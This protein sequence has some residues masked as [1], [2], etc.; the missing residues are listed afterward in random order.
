MKCFY[1]F[2]Q[3]LA[4]S[5]IRWY[6]WPLLA[7]LLRPYRCIGCGRR[8][9]GFLWSGS[10]DAHHSGPIW[11]PEALAN[12]LES[13]DAAAMTTIHEETIVA[14]SVPADGSSEAADTQTDVL[15]LHKH[16]G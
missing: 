10:G 1:C 14:E 11:L 5:R 8:S 13:H 3:G 12:R 7:L 15:R 6:D 2:R 4:R 16:A 9:I